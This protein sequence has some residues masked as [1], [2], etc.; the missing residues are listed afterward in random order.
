MRLESFVAG[1]DA[2]TAVRMLAAGGL[3]LLPVRWVASQRG[4]RRDRA[5]EGASDGM[6][7]LVALLCA[8]AAFAMV[9]VSGA[10]MWS[11][12]RLIA[13]TRPVDAEIR[14]CGI[15][16]Q[17]TGGRDASTVYELWCEVAVLA[18]TSLHTVRAGFPTKRSKYEAWIDTHPAGTRVGL[19]APRGDPH[20]VTGF[21]TLVPA[22]TTSAHASRFALGSGVG[23]GVALLGAVMLRRRRM[24]GAPI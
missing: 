22:T 18:D 10:R 17:R 3:A 23:A 5:R 20:T 7:L 2:P 24:R 11:E 13:T 8:V 4:P 6:L 21:T 15:T 9:A 16:E 19:R 12:Y 1:L 14:R